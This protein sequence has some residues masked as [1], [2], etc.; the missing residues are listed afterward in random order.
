MGVVPV[1]ACRVSL[2]P[3]VLLVVVWGGDLVGFCCCFGVVLLL[4]GHLMVVALGVVIGL[5]L[6]W[7]FM[8]GCCF[9][10][11]YWVFVLGC[12]WFGGCYWVVVLGVVGLLLVWG[13]LLG[14][15]VG[16]MLGCCC[17]WWLLLGCHAGVVVG[18][19]FGGS[20]L[21]CSFWGCC[22]AVVISGS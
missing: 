22:W 12:F 21:G 10:C 19:F 18:L 20:L 6:C 4:G 14:C 8:L 15:C 13:S 7:E 16:S 17:C 5:K 9:G 2:L 1:V 11:H 3:G